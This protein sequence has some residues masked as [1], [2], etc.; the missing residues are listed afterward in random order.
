MFLV[1][2]N[3]FRDYDPTLGGYLTSD[4]VGL[5]GGLNTYG[6]VSGNPVNV[7][8]PKGLDG[9]ARPRGLEEFAKQ[10]VRNPSCI[11]VIQRGVEAAANVVGAV[12]TATLVE[13]CPIPGIEPRE[14]AG[15]K[16]GRC[17]IKA[18]EDLGFIEIDPF[19]TERR[20]TA[21]LY[22]CEDGSQ[23]DL[24]GILQRSSRRNR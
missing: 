14:S 16:K 11:Q 4:P 21:C 10:C 15:G 23:Q 5:I 22:A 3:Y 20:R 24:Q 9:S 19:G 18:E 12:F 6:Y 13:S 7:V 17:T 1:L 8:D 2:Y